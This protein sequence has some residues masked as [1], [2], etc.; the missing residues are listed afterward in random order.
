MR[1]LEPG[2]PARSGQLILERRYRIVSSITGS[3]LVDAR[4]LDIGCG[5]GAQTVYFSSVSRHLIGLDIL[6]P[7]ETAVKET[8]GEFD[9][10]RGSGMELP[11]DD[12]VF[13]IVTSF[14]VLEHLPDDEK[15]VAEAIR[16]LKSGGI[17]FITVPNK[18]WIFESHGAVIPGVNL[19]PWNRVPFFGWLPRR[20]HERFARARTY[21]MKRALELVR[22][23]GFDIIDNGYLTAPLD[24]LNDTVLRRTLRRTVFKSDRTRIPFLAVNLFVAVRKCESEKV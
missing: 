1:H 2:R 7:D 14:E 18:W 20:I 21:T 17:L 10:V 23:R 8:P 6:P 12:G 3:E 4:M 9:F 15:A 19:I 11:F 5:N 13:D 22:D 16:V 24:V